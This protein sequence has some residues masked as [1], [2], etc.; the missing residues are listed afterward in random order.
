MANPPTGEAD[1]MRSRLK[2]LLRDY[3][4]LDAKVKA[5]LQEFGFDIADDGKHIKIIFQGDDRYTFTMPKSGSDLRGGLN[6]AG[7]ISRLLL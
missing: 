4:S 7:D 2:S 5:G 1:A 6:L 3:R